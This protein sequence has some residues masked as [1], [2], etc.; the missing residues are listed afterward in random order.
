MRFSGSSYTLQAIKG[1]YSQSLEEFNTMKH[2][3]ETLEQTNKEDRENFETK[4]SKLEDEKSTL[5]SENNQFST[6]VGEL[7]TE[8]ENLRNYKSTVES[9]IKKDIIENYST[10]LSDEIISKF[11]EKI[12][13]YSIEDLKKEL[14]YTL[15]G[16]DPTKFSK[17]T[18][19]RVPKPSEPSAFEALLDKYKKD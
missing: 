12:E 18:T 10:Q 19:P 8:V 9:N 17:Q 7:T 16:D 13:D 14:A 11:T 6:Q 15:V 3:Y 5:E 2:N 4:I 1:T